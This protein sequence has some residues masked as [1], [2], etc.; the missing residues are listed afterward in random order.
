MKN[1]KRSLGSVALLALAGLSIGCGRTTYET[2]DVDGDTQPSIPNPYPTVT[3]SPTP[4]PTPSTGIPPISHSFEITGSGTASFTV[5]TDNVLKVRI[6]PDTAGL[7]SGSGFTAVYSCI[8][9]TVT[10]IGKSVPTEVLQV[11]GGGLN[12]PTAKTEQIINFSDRLGTGHNSVTITVSA[13]KTDFKY[14]NC[15]Q[16]PWLYSAYPYGYYSCDL[17]KPLTNLYTTHVATGVIDI[18]VNGTDL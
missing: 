18:Q 13:V 14:N 7:V 10:V 2:P 12:C 9:Y 1:F 15:L 16:S 17:Y 3:P 5:D 8:K 4:S 6:K 11:G